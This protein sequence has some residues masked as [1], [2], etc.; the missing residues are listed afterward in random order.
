MVWKYSESE[1]NVALGHKF[2]IEWQIET[3]MKSMH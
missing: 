1:N 2:E 3:K